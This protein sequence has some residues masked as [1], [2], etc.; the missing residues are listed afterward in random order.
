M[1]ER[2]ELNRN[3]WPV[4]PVLH[5][6]ADREPFDIFFCSSL[7]ADTSLNPLFDDAEF[8]STYV[9]RAF[10]YLKLWGAGQSL[11]DFWFV[12]G[13][14]MGDHAECLETLMR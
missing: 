1:G 2:V 4:L 11:D 8:R 6:R 14:V 7:A 10:Q 12:P 5:V 13:Q 9:Q 3:K